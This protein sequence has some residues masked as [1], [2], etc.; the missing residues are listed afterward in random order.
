MFF[1]ILDISFFLNTNSKYAD[2]IEK[3]EVEY[4]K[5]NLNLQKANENNQYIFFF[6]VALTKI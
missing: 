5:Q 4:K 6:S 3:V 1:I 2:I